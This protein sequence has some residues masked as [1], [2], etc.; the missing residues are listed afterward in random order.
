MRF[1]LSNLHCFVLFFKDH[2]LVN[3]TTHS[4][5]WV[6]HDSSFVLCRS[7]LFLLL[8]EQTNFIPTFLIIFWVCNIKKHKPGENLAFQS[9]LEMWLG[10]YSSCSEC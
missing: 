10:V 1:L 9:N 8:V 7:L 5:N 6:C 2:V 4:S 3:C